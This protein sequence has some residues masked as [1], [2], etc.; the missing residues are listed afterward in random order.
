MNN[1]VDIT[2][3]MDI[4]EIL[5]VDQQQREQSSKQQQEREQKRET[6]KSIVFGGGKYVNKSI[7]RLCNMSDEEIDAEYENYQ[8]RIGAVMVKTL[9]K[10]FLTLYSNMVSYFIDIDDTA[11]LIQDLNEDPFIDNAMNKTCCELYH[12]YVY[13]LLQ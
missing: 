13:Q 12:K 8:R 1:Y 6:L 10:A 2:R 11:E 7:D 3:K 4:E 5:G 9:G